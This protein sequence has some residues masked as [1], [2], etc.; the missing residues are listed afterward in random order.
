MTTIELSRKWKKGDRIG[1][2]GG[3]GQVFEAIADD[4]SDA[5]IKLVPK[6]PG[7][8]R[9]LLFE[10]LSGLPNIIPIL[11]S[12]EWE[13][14]Y[15]LAMPRA[16]RSLRQHL[17]DT[18]GKLSVVDAV[19]ILKDV[20]EALAALDA[21]VVHR[22]IKPENV[23]LYEG[24][25]CLADFGIARYAEAATEPETRKFSMTRQY[26]APEQWRG[27]R[28][29]S[30]TDVYAFGVMAF[31]LTQGGFPFAG[32]DYREQHLHKPAPEL[33]GCPAA[34]VGLITECMYKPAE[35]R[36]SAANILARLSSV[37]RPGS[38]AEEKLRTVQKDVAGRQARAA[39]AASE[40][41]SRA[42]VRGE[43]IAVA[44][45]SLGPIVDLLQERIVS[46]A[47]AADGS[48]RAGMIR[49]EE[50]TMTVDGIQVGPEECLAARGFDAPFDVIAF[51]AVAVKRPRD[52]YDYDGRSH[53]LWFCDAHDEGQ[54]RWFE[55]AFTISGLRRE[56][57]TV[58]PFAA[59]PTDSDVADC[60]TP[61]SFTRFSLARQPVPFDQ[62]E[63][64]SFIERWLDWFADAAAGKLEMPKGMPEHTGGRVRQTRERKRNPSPGSWGSSIRHV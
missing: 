63:E 12:G 60:F 20:A 13:D 31:E 54:Y 18:G 15:V 26:A 42:E 11:D 62:G 61:V 25:W 64:D 33:K 4:G 10:E 7:A 3:F 44:K 8:S 29:T 46:A 40:K 53:S 36:P 19:E 30:A 32:P 24:H 47:P 43:L 38:P 27:E 51:T 5:V 45:Q 52:A 22:D 21:S 56:R 49:L 2:P 6:E 34:L 37:D 39:A 16:E 48:L 59:P 9:E 57:S 55:L 1:D 50:A 23:L 14:Y 35:A 28:A 17:R 58:D 41:Q